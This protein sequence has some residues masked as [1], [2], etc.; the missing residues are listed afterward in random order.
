MKASL[1]SSILIPAALF[2]FTR[3]VLEP[4]LFSSSPRCLRVPDF[5]VGTATYLHIAALLLAMKALSAG[6]GSG[7]T[8][9]NSWMR[10]TSAHHRKAG[11]EQG[12]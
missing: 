4:C 5:S 1:P 8:C 11:G 3:I 6:T 9:A 12:D 7:S 10:A 2:W